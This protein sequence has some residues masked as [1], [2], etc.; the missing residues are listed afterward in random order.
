M[1]HGDSGLPVERIIH[2]AKR[3]TL[4]EGDLYWCGA[5]NVLMWCITREDDCEVLIE[6]HGGECVNHASS[7]TLVSKAFR[8]GFY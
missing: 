7:R 3:Y 4:V 2:V 6:I 1:D 5:N 8:Y